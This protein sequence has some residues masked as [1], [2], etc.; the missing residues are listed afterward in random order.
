MRHTFFLLLLL[1][2]ACGGDSPAVKLNVGQM[3]PAFEG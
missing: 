3:A 1:L 2:A